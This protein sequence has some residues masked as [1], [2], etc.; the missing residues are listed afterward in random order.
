MLA[1]ALRA[2][3]VY[4]R[5]RQE[6]ALSGYIWPDSVAEICGYDNE[7][8]AVPGGYV[9]AEAI[10]HTGGHVDK[11]MGDGLMA[12]W[13]LVEDTAAARRRTCEQA[14]DAA[15]DAVGNVGKLRLGAQPCHLQEGSKCREIYAVETVEERHRHRYEVNN[16]YVQQ[17]CDAGMRIAGW[18]ADRSLVEMVEIPG[19]PWFVACQFHPEFTSRPRGGH[20][21]FTSY[22]E[23]A[24]AHREGDDG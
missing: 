11:F 5:P 18:S 2:A 7:W 13:I 12:F 9:Q 6:A 8:V 14:V 10:R 20:P 19:H 23:A 17:L 21:L 15:L 22:I 4:R 3:P 1:R 24:I 16:N